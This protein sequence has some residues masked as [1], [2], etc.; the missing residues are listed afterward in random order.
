MRSLLL[1]LALLLAPLACLAASASDTLD[2]IRLLAAGGAPAL[3]LRTLDGVQ[4]AAAT[5]A[6]GWMQWER[7]RV[8]ILEA[9][10]EWRHLAERLAQLPAGLPTEFRRWALTQRARAELQRG[11]GTD[12]RR[13]LREL[14]WDPALSAPGQRRDWRRMIVHSYLLDQRASDAEHA[15]VRLQQDY[16]SSEPA[17]LRLRA[18]ASLLS[19]HA[20]DAVRLLQGDARQGP[21]T[22]AL[23]LL[24]RLRSG[25]APPRRVMQAA[26]HRLRG[27]PAPRVETLLW[28]VAAEAAAQAGDLAT[29]VNATEHVLAAGP[30]AALPG[31]VFALDADGL[32]TAYLSYARA[33]GNRAQYL[34]GDDARWLQAAGEAAQRYPVRA[35]SL[36]AMVIRHGQSE[37]AQTR[38]ARA[39][40][41]SLNA[42]R[43]GD[44]LLKQLFLHGKFYAAP[45]AIP[46]PVRRRL[47]DLAL[48]DSDIRLASRL[49]ATLDQPPAAADRFRWGVRRAR[50]LVMGGQ[51]R[52]GAQA[53]QELLDGSG[54]LGVKRLRHLLQVV[55]DL[56]TVGEHEAALALLARLLKLSDD[57]QFT[58]ELLYWMAESEDKLERPRAA[59]R[60]YLRSALLPGADTMDPWAQTARFQAAKALAQAGLVG[61]AR[62]LLKQ[63]LEVTTDTGRRAVLQRELEGLWLVRSPGASALASP[64]SAP[65]D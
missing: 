8:R 37:A 6:P 26:L 51:P 17:D 4:P 56:Q 55:F 35:R 42:R 29:Q 52:A 27:D 59:A 15:I 9:S 34:I 53:L 3:A 24:A 64:S 2:Q 65:V 13:T 46:V 1:A 36:Y 48:A 30:Q 57:A 43:G 31:G 7:E 18:R 28:A 41:A 21:Q 40:V 45:A 12:A 25:Q 16:P 11:A 32:W 60:L 22:Q 54:E 62:R 39:L 5:D 38:A 23:L 63:L 10:G 44:R 19:G 14:L 50:I 61:D 33:L 47:V 49:M 58:R 20:G